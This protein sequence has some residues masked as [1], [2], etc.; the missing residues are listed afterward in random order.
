MLR[1]AGRRE[2]IRPAVL[3]RF[4]DQPLHRLGIFDKTDG[5]LGQRPRVRLPQRLKIGEE[6]ARLRQVLFRLL[7]VAAMNGLVGPLE[8]PGLAIMD[9]LDRRIGVIRVQ[10]LQPFGR[11]ND[12]R[13]N[14][15][16]H[17]HLGGRMKIL[18]Q[19]K[20]PPGT[21]GVITDAEEIGDQLAVMAFQFIAGRAIDDV[22]AEMFPPLVAPVRFVKP[23][24]DKNQFEDVLRNGVEP[25]VEFVRI[26][27]VRR[28]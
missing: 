4:Q 11:H 12:R 21:V 10:M 14:I 8:E 7:V 13:G 6:I 25:L 3:G 2:I 24:H 26:I 1:M 28:A 20:H 16:L 9:K 19:P 18:A 5:I 17:L 23:F 27:A 22:H 15:V